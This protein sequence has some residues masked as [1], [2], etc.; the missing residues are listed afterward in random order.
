[1]KHQP[2]GRK[3]PPWIGH[4][5]FLMVGGSNVHK[6]SAECRKTIVIHMGGFNK[7]GIPTMD[8][9]Y[10]GNSYS[11]GWFRVTPN[12]GN[13]QDHIAILECFLKSQIAIEH[14]IQS[15]ADG[16]PGGFPWALGCRSS[17]FGLATS[18][19]DSDFDRLL[20]DASPCLP[21]EWVPMRVGK[22][23]QTVAIQ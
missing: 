11:K 19:A 1:M 3:L 15:S 8:G 22:V 6:N 23:S 20:W 5:D 7:W 10:N 21:M 16:F 2:L 12:S 14:P 17:G 13:H 4:P 9:V 18:L